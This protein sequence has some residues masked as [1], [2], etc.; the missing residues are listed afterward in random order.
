VLV[1]ALCS[2]SGASKA[3]EQSGARCPARSQSLAWQHTHDA[4]L[5]A[6]LHDN[7]LTVGP[8]SARERIDTCLDYGAVAAN[9]AH[10]GCHR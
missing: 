3:R 4:V 2:C 10:G 1:V 5:A 6:C 7:L 8:E 9:R